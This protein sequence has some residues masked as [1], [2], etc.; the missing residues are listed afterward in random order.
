MSVIAVLLGARLLTAAADPAGSTPEPSPVSVVVDAAVVDGDALAARLVAGVEPLSRRL[1]P[2]TG[3]AVS[4]HV[5]GELLDFR[6]SLALG[7]AG[8]SSWSRCACT[9]AE[10]VA[11]VQE[12]LTQELRARPRCPPPPRVVVPPPSPTPPRVVVPPHSPAS[13]RPIVPHR[14]LGRR[15]RLGVALVALGGL[16]LGAGI[17]AATATSVVDGEQW[18]LHTLSR[19]RGLVPMVVGTGV[20]AT[21]AF[22][23]IF[24]R[25]LPRARLRAVH[26]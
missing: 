8:A 26:P 19:P 20:L 4:I 25:R 1:R 17:G 13:P 15:D 22:L 7:P 10:L 12:R 2:M 16:V 21:G 23:L 6:V 5:T 11:H 18:S 9:H 24:D 3:A 14:S